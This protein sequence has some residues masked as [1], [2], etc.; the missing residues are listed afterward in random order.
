MTKENL[1]NRVDALVGNYSISTAIV[2]ECTTQVPNNYKKCIK[3]VIGV[4]NA[5]SSIFKK[6]M[7]P[8][9]NGFGLMYK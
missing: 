2:E 4:S 6:A 5:E 9:N 8:S 3:D 1:I 7:Y